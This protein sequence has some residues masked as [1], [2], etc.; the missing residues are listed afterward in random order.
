MIMP[1]IE[2]RNQGIKAIA[3]GRARFEELAIDEL[4]ALFAQ[5]LMRGGE[6]H[7]EAQA[8]G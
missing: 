5:R 8:V 6:L 3:R 1:G 4:V 7:G 2:S